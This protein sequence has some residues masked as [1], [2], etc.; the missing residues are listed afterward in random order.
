MTYLLIILGLLGGS[1][2]AASPQTLSFSQLKIE[3]ELPQGKGM[4]SLED[5][6]QLW[7]EKEVAIRGF[8]YQQNHRWILAAEPHLKSCCIGTPRTSM[9]QIYLESLGD[10]IGASQHPVTIKGRLMIEPSWEGDQLTQLFVMKNAQ[11]EQPS[12]RSFVYFVLGLGLLISLGMLIVLIR[13]S[14][15]DMQELE[16]LNNQV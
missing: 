16:R 3:H 10:L 12:S 1:L 4:E 6:I 8:L 9:N 13:H 2:Q 11:L 7:H 15:R 5:A 14:R